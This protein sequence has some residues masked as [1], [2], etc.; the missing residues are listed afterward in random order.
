MRSDD[1]FSLLHLSDTDLIASTKSLAARVREATAALVAHL[2]EIDARGLHL[3]EGYGSLFVYCREALALSE[4]EAYFRIEAARVARSFPLVLEM[5][6]EGSIN[7][8][9][10]KLLTPHLSPENHEHLLESARGKS[11]RQVEEMV[12]ALMPFPDVPPS[13]RKLPGPVS[14]V[15]EDTVPGT[16]GHSPPTLH[17]TPPMPPARPAVVTPLA[18]DRYKMQLT[19]SGDTL[20]KLRLAKDLLRHAVPSGDDAVVVERALTV[21]LADLAKKKFAAASEPRPAPAT[22]PGSRHIPAEVKRAVFLR[23]LGRCAFVGTN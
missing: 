10:V 16:P 14:A 12:A 15:P 13:I 11:K 1:R 18:P 20:E 19:I 7:L 22:R 17:P 4:A 23:D 21:L 2:A 3:R 5:L 8:S 9:T 6:A